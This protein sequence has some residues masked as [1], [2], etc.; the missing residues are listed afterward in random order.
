M[1]LK[2]AIVALMLLLMLVGILSMNFK[3]T[4]NFKSNQKRTK[5]KSRKS[6]LQGLSLKE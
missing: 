3:V 1:N 4:V 6:N 5:R 2:I